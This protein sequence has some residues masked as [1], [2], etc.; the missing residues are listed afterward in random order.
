MEIL[1]VCGFC[2]GDTKDSLTVMGS[3]ADG[4][5]CNECALKVV[6]KH[7]KIPIE[8]IKDALDNYPFIGSV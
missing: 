3:M 4:Y 5:V 2:A 1:K 6:S 8:K 7:Y